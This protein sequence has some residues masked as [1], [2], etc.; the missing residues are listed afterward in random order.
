MKKKFH[1][2]IPLS[3]KDSFE[4]LCKSGDDITTWKTSSTD[5]ENGYIMWKQSFMSLTG[6]ATIIAKLEQTKE[7]ETSVEVIV[8]KPLQFFDPIKI[9]DKVFNK[10]D[11]AWQKNFKNQQK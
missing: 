5:P 11:K 7:K 4:L 3:F 8:H 10:L 1:I 6:T 9:S 2:R